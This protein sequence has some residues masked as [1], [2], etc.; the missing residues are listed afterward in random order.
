MVCKVDGVRSEP[1]PTGLSIQEQR[2]NLREDGGVVNLNIVQHTPIVCSSS[3]CSS[4]LIIQ[5]R[6]SCKLFILIFRFYFL[7][8]VFFRCSSNTWIFSVVGVRPADILVSRCS[9]PLRE[10]SECDELGCGNHTLQVRD[11]L[12]FIKKFS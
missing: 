2:L 8:I 4:Q 7:F 5:S 10:I 3:P 9:I 12:G 11:K 1:Y 6:N